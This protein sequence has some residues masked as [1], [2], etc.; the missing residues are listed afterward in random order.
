M[1]KR[2]TITALLGTLKVLA[3]FIV[4]FIIV[5]AMNAYVQ[6]IGRFI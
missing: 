6:L 4:A 2:K 3:L 1:I 5:A